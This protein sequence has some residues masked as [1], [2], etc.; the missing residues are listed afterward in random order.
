MSY[1]V[2]IVLEPDATLGKY[3]LISRLGAGGMGEVWKAEDT[4]LGRS[5]AIKILPPDV[6][7][8][9]EA[10][11]RMR[12]EARTAA[13]LYHPNI[14]TIH[15]IEEVDGRLFIVME[16][17][18]GEPLT[19]LVRRG[20]VSEADVC[21]IGRA[22]ADALAEAHAKGIVHRDIKPDNI[23]VNGPRVKVLDF[24]I[25]KQIGGIS[26]S[27]DPTAVLTR[28]GM[29]IGTVLYMS[30][31]QALGKELDARTDLFSLGVVLYELATG[32][33]PF[34]GETITETITKIV[35]DEPE[36]LRGLTPGLEGIIRRCLEKDR[37]RRFANASQ[38]ASA[39]EA[40][41]AKAPTAPYTDVLPPPAPPTVITAAR[42][43]PA[44]APHRW[45][46]VAGVVLLVLGAAIGGFV[47]AR[48]QTPALQT[49]STTTTA[50][51]TAA[52]VPATQVVEV[53][54]EPPVVETH[55]PVP[56]QVPAP[57][58]HEPPPPPTAKEHFGEG[59]AALHERRMF[60][61]R[62]EFELA[63]MHR[64]EL[65]Q[66][67]RLFADLGIALSF[68]NRLRARE[69]GREILAISPNDPDLEDLRR[70]FEEEP[71]PRGPI[72]P[73]PFPRRRP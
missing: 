26:K 14:A 72:R 37:E 8:D 51:T 69:L 7:S 31:E 34:R 54:T 49:P 56:V 66:R 1:N 65:D 30:P 10:V 40:H 3:R 36:P 42:P 27:D 21:R 17:A 16:Y 67:E 50:V 13:Q 62:R 60:E 23:V 53:T 2:R 15:A 24:G 5:V 25:A 64:D 22:V 33:L 20:H 68:G 47:I 55:A 63:L 32:R 48:S 45:P 59:M 4:H 29:I 9:P 61:A 6:A 46:W 58:M 44:P 41:L 19:S 12:R 39:L 38:L 71:P 73:R 70:E 57:A 28:A 35:R 11:A 43:A 52:P 18:E